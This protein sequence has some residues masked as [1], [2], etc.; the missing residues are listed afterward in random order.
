MQQH[1]EYE[2]EVFDWEKFQGRRDVTHSSWFKFY[3]KFW[4]DPRV[5]RLS[6]KERYFFVWL[7]SICCEQSSSVCTFSVRTASKN[8]S[9]RTRYVQVVI[10][11]LEQN[12]LVK[13]I[14]RDGHVARK[15]ERKTDRGG[16]TTAGLQA[17]SFP[18][19]DTPD[20]VLTPPPTPAPPKKGPALDFDALYLGYP[21]KEGKKDGM[22]TCRN[23]IKTVA[24]YERFRGAITR[25]VAN[26]KRKK[27]ESR[28]VM[29]F[30]TFANNWEEWTSPDAGTV[31]LNAAPEQKQ[32]LFDVEEEY[33][34]DGAR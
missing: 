32:I 33:V 19:E 5:E 26:L 16:L 23:S 27:T 22:R 30:S 4:N 3:I 7:M 8:T 17:G 29:K 34:Q 24:D 25:Y 1:I 18:K 28:Y 15:K 20:F 12:Q 14:R 21:R 10:D 11:H 13:I 9:I 6:V 31:S 2:I